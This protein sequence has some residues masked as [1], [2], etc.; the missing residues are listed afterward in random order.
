MHLHALA[1]IIVI[2]AGAVVGGAA[3]V[4]VAVPVVGIASVAL[5]HVRDYRA[6]ETLVREHEAMKRERE[7]ASAARAG[8][9]TAMSPAREEPEPPKADGPKPAA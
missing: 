3:G 8:D 1:V 2:W 6:I 5:R 7:A 4:L 9:G